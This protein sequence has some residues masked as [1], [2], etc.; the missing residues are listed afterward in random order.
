M[1]A[2]GKACFLGDH[3]TE[4]LKALVFEINSATLLV[5]SHYICLVTPFFYL[6]SEL[7]QGK[8]GTTQLGN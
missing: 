3:I 4:Y 2:M 7:N 6:T 1:G 8:T 5:K